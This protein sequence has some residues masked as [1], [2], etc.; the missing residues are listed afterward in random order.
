M[1]NGKLKDW[2][3]RV[4]RTFVQGA[5]GVFVLTYSATIFKLAQDFSSLGPGDELPPLP[6]LNFLRNMLL[7]LFAGGVIACFSLLWNGLE[8]LTGT[9]VLKPESPPASGTVK[10]V[11]KV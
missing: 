1:Q 3:A 9:G 5:I 6:D 2:L 7:A 11:A 4:L 8:E 10:T